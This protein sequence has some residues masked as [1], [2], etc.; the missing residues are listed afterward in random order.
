MPPPSTHYISLLNLDPQ[1]DPLTYEYSQED[2]TKELELFTNSNFLDTEPFFDLPR[3]DTRATQDAA[4]LPFDLPTL[5]TEFTSPQQQEPQQ[6]QEQ[7]QIAP[8]QTRSSVYPTILPAPPQ[9]SFNGKYLSSPSSFDVNNPSLS[10][11]ITNSK[12]YKSDESESYD[13]RGDRKLEDEDKRRR[14]TAAS[15]RFRI[16]KKQREQALQAAAREN[17]DRVQALENRITELA[18]ENKWLRSLLKPVDMRQ[19]RDALANV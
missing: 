5:D 18:L 15:A 13:S 7:V 12:K 2:I 11:Y 17:A 10:A 6:E 16:K 14:N 9:P 19:A 3:A 1:F 4:N 8:T